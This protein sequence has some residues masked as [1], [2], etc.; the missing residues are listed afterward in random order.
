MSIAF[1]RISDYLT[2][3]P[4]EESP[5]WSSEDVFRVAWAQDSF[6]MLRATGKG[7]SPEYRDEILDEWLGMDSTTIGIRDRF[8]RVGELFE[9][10][11]RAGAAP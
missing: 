6:A 10:Q 8:R 4:H 1:R 2:E 5:E 9:Q 11:F 3:S 7:F